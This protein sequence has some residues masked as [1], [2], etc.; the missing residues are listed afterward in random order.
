MVLVFVSVLIAKISE[1]VMS[2]NLWIIGSL[3]IALGLT[4]LIFWWDFLKRLYFTLFRDLRAGLAFAKTR[5]FLYKY[6]DWNV[7]RL[8]TRLVEKHPDKVFLYYKDEKWTY[9]DVEQFSNR[10]AN[11]FRSIGFRKNDEIALVMNTRPE[12]IAT[13][14]GLSKCGIVTAF[15][16]TNQRMETLVHSITVVNC[17]AVIFDVTLAKNILEA[18]SMI[19]SK[20]PGMLYYSYV[21]RDPPSIKAW[22]R[23]QETLMKIGGKRLDDCLETASPFKPPQ[24]YEQ[25][26]SDKLYYIFTSGTTGLPKAAVIRHHRYIWIGMILH[27][28]FNISDDDILY[29]TLPQYHNNAGTIG[30]CQGVILGTGIVLREKFSASQFWD[31][32]IRYNCTVAMYIGELCRY[33]LAQPKKSTDSMHKV[34]LMFGN[35]LRQEIWR[36][37]KNRFNIKQI[38]EVYGSTEGNANVANYDFTEGACGIIPCCV[39]FICRL[40]FP[41]T[42]IKVDPAT[43]EHVRGRNG[44]CKLIKPGE[45]GE[46]VGKIGHDPGKSYPGY[47]NN[48]ATK[49]K[50]IF[51]VFN[52]GDSAFLSGDLVEMDYYGYL[53]FRDRTGDT[54]RWKGENVSTNEVEAVIQKVVQLSDCI[55]F[56]VSIPNCDGKA[57]MAVIADP[58]QIVDVENLFQKLEKRLPPF[59][60]PLF[61]RITQ[62][63]DLTA[64]FK[65]SKTSLEKEGYNLLK[66]S[67]PI[68]FLDRKLQKYIPLTQSL[69][70]EIQ[71]GKLL[72]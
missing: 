53:Y 35:G 26:M 57:G 28:L 21:G 37:F 42:V 68:Y 67:D 19:E 47:V 49:K 7:P 10:I 8:F 33:L 11:Y 6:R 44:L 12:F 9:D 45:I 32:C 54:F 43:G 46:I 69:Y 24:I 62:K 50:I 64:S 39:P 55:V 52:H 58:Q 70:D 2:F 72:L 15:I 5:Y 56:G 4:I 18:Q 3:L 36:D 14:L 1:E 27:N 51:N 17:K 23:D 65:L 63:I 34:R 31:D 60:V 20:K 22:E 41:V 48:E 38:G 13:W 40:I 16:N 61:I 71:N 66:F 29:L 25:K 59:A 30:S